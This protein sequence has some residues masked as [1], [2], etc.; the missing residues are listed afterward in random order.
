MK[1]YSF[2]K[3][4]ALLLALIMVIPAIPL[5]A[6]ASTSNYTYK[7]PHPDDK[8]YV[9]NLG[10]WL[11]SVK[12]SSGNFIIDSKDDLIYFMMCGQV[13]STKI[14]L[15]NGSQINTHFYSKT[16]KLGS[17]IVWN[18][19]TATADGF[20]P[21]SGSV[22]YTW[23][24]WWN[25]TTS[26]E[27][28]VS[29]WHGFRGTFDGNGH[30]IS[31]LVIKE[32][33]YINPQQT[34]AGFFRRT[35]NSATIKNLKFDNMYVS[36]T[37]GTSA[38]VAATRGNLTIDNVGINA[39][40]VGQMS[41]GGFLGHIDGSANS[42][43]TQTIAISN[44]AISGSVSAVGN[45]SS[46]SARIAGGFIGSTGNFTVANFTDCVCYASV[47]AS[48]MWYGGFIGALGSDAS[49]TR[50][51]YLGPQSDSFNYGNLVTIVD[52]DHKAWPGVD[53]SNTLTYT[54]SF[55]DVYYNTSLSNSLI[56]FNDGQGFDRFTV[57]TKY[58]NEPETSVYLGESGVLSAD[59]L[60]AANASFR[61]FDVSAGN[62]DSIEIRGV[63][64]GKS[65]NARIITSINSTAGIKELGYEVISQSNLINGNT[66]VSISC[67]TAYKSINTNFGL[68]QITAGVTEGFTDS[69]YL[70]AL[71][72]QNINAT[73]ATTVLVRNY[74]VTTKGTMLYTDYMAI[75]FAV[76]ANP[77]ILG[78]E[79]VDGSALDVMLACS[80][81]TESYDL[82]ALL[83]GSDHKVLKNG[84]ALNSPIVDL[85]VGVNVFNVTY[86]ENGVN[87]TREV[88][89]ARREGHRVV[90]NTNGGSFIDTKYVT[91][92]ATIN[93]SS[94]TPT[95]NNYTFNGWYDV[96]GNKIT[97]SQYPI[98]EDTTLIAHWTG[99]ISATATD[100]QPIEYTTSS[101]T[102]NINWKDYADAFN[103][104]PSVVFCTLKNTNTGV[105]YTVKVTKYS[106]AFVGSSP[107]GASISQ[108]AG[109]WTV[110][111]TN[112]AATSSYSF[113]MNDLGDQEYTTV[114][115]GTTVTNTVKRYNPLYDDSSALMTE[116]GRFYDVAGNVVVIKGVVPWNVD[117]TK[118]EAGTS[119]LALQRMKEEGCNAI[120]ITVPLG[121][122]TGY[123]NISQEKRELYIAKM[124][125]AADRATAL[126]MYCIL[127]W[128][129]MAQN[130]LTSSER[131]NHLNGLLDPAKEFFGAMSDIYKDNPYVIY[132]LANEPLVSSWNVLKTWETQLINHIRGYNPYAVIIAAPN[133][134]SRRLS[135]EGTKNDPIDSPFATE[136]SYNIAHTFHCYAYTT[137][138]N[139]S[140]D[141]R[142]D[143]IYGWRVCDAIENGLTVIITEFSPANASMS[144]E[145]GYD[146]YGL[147]A[148]YEEAAKWINLILENDINYTM[149]RFGESP[150]R[151]T[152]VPAQ[153]MFIKG[154]GT[155]GFNGT[156]TYDMLSES[157]RWYY[158]NFLNST[159]FI[160][161]A[162][163]SFRHPYT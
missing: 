85:D 144:Y 10:G 138:Y 158:D 114:Q 75:T 54:V 116:N 89:I 148:D 130:S 49:F 118:F 156:W 102:L 9:N 127:D 152:N 65:S 132:E 23:S 19:G 124:K 11:E 62:T 68:G 117:E 103:T 67:D 27:T 57:T 119:T 70:T 63:Q 88:R 32:T 100:K 35:G 150:G 22:I 139:V 115:S 42:Y 26:E 43:A 160:K 129:V 12:D 92:F 64:L 157:G 56:G 109:N 34:G 53:S 143:A 136:I 13:T 48:D 101:A 40:V 134:H 33:T 52:L 71:V 111:I 98:T 8:T 112:L 66:P 96:Y 104:R 84:K 60:E 123:Q 15:P 146:E 16:F 79:Y 82:A 151:T 141:Y 90:F 2:N 106:A 44:S 162:D 155:Y 147:D 39:H 110:K 47:S 87:K 80:F 93:E 142:S 153:F 55:T 21:S 161:V 36:G 131:D 97:L 18:E 95:R 17:D 83:G 77:M 6:S 76:G 159:G 51:Q 50:C 135:E 58:G 107:A 41:V 61:S 140:Y 94:V 149:F 46:G 5:I 37:R 38:L 145:G 81:D 137:T 78:C 126:G 120:R 125:A 3:A 86:V 69:Q 73:A 31:G 154:N 24:P 45:N 72:I 74:L 105:S 14:D 91:D 30:T 113:V 25:S 20:I 122:T 121:P 163:F 133:M 7:T 28:N 128:G 4:L 1:K 99:P 59:I 29:N 108:G